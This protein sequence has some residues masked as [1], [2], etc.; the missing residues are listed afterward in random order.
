MEFSLRTEAGSLLT[1]RDRKKGVSLGSPRGENAQNEVSVRSGGSKY[2]A[3]SIG[4]T[5]LAKVGAVVP[6]RA[7]P[8]P[9]GPRYHDRLR[10]GGPIFS[11]AEYGVRRSVR[12]MQCDV[13]DLFAVHFCRGKV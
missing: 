11:R 10:P 9:E 6:H 2:E 8:G 7:F 4:S 3:A 12:Q 5:T 1:K 13:L